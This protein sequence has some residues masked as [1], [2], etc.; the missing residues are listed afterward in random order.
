MVYFDHN[1]T[2]PMSAAAQA[3]WLRAA[4]EFPANPSSP[5]RL[6]QRAEAALEDARQ[7]LARL[8]GCSPL[9]LIWTSGA[10]EAANTVL[11]HFAR[12]L[13]PETEI[14]LSAI[15]HPCVLAPARKYFGRRL[16]LIPV[17]SEGVVDLDWLVRH[18]AD[19]RPGLV[20]LMAANNETGVLQ[21]WRELL[22]F[23][24]DRAVPSFI[25]ATQWLGRL[26]A[27]GLGA[28]DFVIGS[29]HK[30]G[31]PKGIG[32]LKCPR[33]T[34]LEPLL[35]GGPQQ[36]GRRA[37]TENVAGVL[38]MV[39]ALEEREA[40]LARGELQPK[41]LQRTVFEAQ[42]LEALPGATLVGAQVPRLWN[43]C[44]VVTPALEC[45]ARW[46]VKLDKLGFA[47]STGSACASGHEAPSHVLTAMGLSQAEAGRAVRISSGW[48]TTAADWQGVGDAFRATYASLQ[49]EA[50]SHSDAPAQSAV[51]VS[52]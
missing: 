30:V 26:P 2:A 23:G 42:L 46:V 31:G 38:A 39:A 6:G 21:L 45:R 8:L 25:D 7:R 29:G 47:V 52:S 17:S 13:A 16:H 14:C 28:A 1:A 34:R 5:H 37:G 22:E 40:A 41:V 43:T 11:H 27:A 10:T 24:R 50:E 15:E 49:E 9:E 20:G 51:T 4:A 44:L 36:E 12:R 48:E 3:A 18:L 35:C 32:F 33:G 19:A